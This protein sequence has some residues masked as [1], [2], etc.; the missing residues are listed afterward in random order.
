MHF[1]ILDLLDFFVQNVVPNSYGTD[2]YQTLN[3]ERNTGIHKSTL[4]VKNS[5]QNIAASLLLIP[6]IILK[7]YAHYEYVP[8]IISY[9]LHFLCISK[10]WSMLHH[11]P[12]GQFQSKECYYMLTYTFLAYFS[13]FSAKFMYFYH[14]H[15]FLWWSIKS[16]QQNINQ[17]ESRID[18]KKLLAELYVRLFVGGEAKYSRYR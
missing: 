8:L 2:F 5:Q 10:I 17:W 1:Y 6:K 9:H 18:E 16:P 11:G 15:I 13:C 14:F 4:P 12:V 3:S 7:M